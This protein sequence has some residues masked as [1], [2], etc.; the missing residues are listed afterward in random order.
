MN[1]GIGE[2]GIAHAH[3]VLHLMVWHDDG[4]TLYAMTGAVM[5]VVKTKIGEI[6]I[7]IDEG[8]DFVESAVGEKDVGNAGLFYFMALAS[9]EFHSFDCGAEGFEPL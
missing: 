8:T 3:Q 9:D 6:D 4:G 2:V 1:D 7:V 5:T